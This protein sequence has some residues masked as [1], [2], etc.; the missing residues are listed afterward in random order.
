M[1]G[2][3]RRWD[4]QPGLRLLQGVAV[5]SLLGLALLGQVPVEVVGWVMPPRVVGNERADRV[6]LRLREQCAGPGHWAAL[7]WY[8]AE[9]WP[10][11]LLRSLVLWG[12]WVR[13]GEWGPAWLRL[14]PWGLWLWQGLGVGWPELGEGAPWCWVAC[15]LWQGQR[16]LLVGYLGLALNRQRSGELGLSCLGLGC[17][18]CVPSGTVGEAAADPWVSVARQVDGSYQVTLSG[19]FTLSVAAD[20]PFRMRLL[21]LFLSLLDVP[22]MERGS[23]RTRDGRTPFVRQMQLAEWFGVSQPEISR[24]LRY[25]QA[26][27]WADLLSLRNNVEVLTAELMARIVEVFATFPHWSAEQVYQHLRQQG[28]VV[29]Q[30][31]VAQTAEQSG[32]AG[33]RQTLLERYD[34]SG[35]VL[36]LRDEWLVGQLLRQL[37]DLLGRLEGGGGLTT[38][39]Q[40]RAA[41]LTVLAAEA[42]VVAPPVKALP[43]LLRVEQVVFGRWQMATDSQVRCPYCAQTRSGVRASSPV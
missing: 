2:T 34:L 22:G 18:E 16:L 29:T 36:R 42:G 41:D 15:G 4:N 24:W 37:G 10:P 7:G 43:W 6:R 12:L 27:R 31:Q 20:H 23:R 17:L 39:V 1:Q 38:E 8:L 26:G 5:L 13:S 11:V 9:S 21:V 32:W 30:A 25:W 28:V 33:L 3:T 19:H 40:S 35:S 14:V